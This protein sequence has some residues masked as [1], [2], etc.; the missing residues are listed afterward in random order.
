MP[1]L[2]ITALVLFILIAARLITERPKLVQA[3]N[4]IAIGIIFLYLS[5]RGITAGRLP[6]MGVFEMNLAEVMSITAL[7]FWYDQREDKKLLWRVAPVS[8][9]LLLHALSTDAT[10]VPFT[11]SE[12]SIWVD[13]HSLSAWITWAFLANALVLSFDANESKLALRLFGWTFF[14]MT[15]CGALGSY[16]GSILFATAWEWDL[17]QVL[18]ILS[19]ILA[20]WT[21]HWSLFFKTP[22]YRIRGLVMTTFL[23]WV[24]ASKILIYLPMGQSFHVFELGILGGP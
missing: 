15:L 6:I 23:V 8:F 7:A 3:L 9:L 5:Y 13:L 12:Q 11:I 24:L 20:A 4:L 17:V 10:L 18:G 2:V 14:W 21:L 22:I 19:W 1:D 16:Y